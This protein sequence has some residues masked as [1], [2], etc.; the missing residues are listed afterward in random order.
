[1]DRGMTIPVDA[2]P[3]EATAGRVMIVDDE[4]S[5]RELLRDLL[6]LWGH[7]VV[8]AGSGE[9]AIR[10]AAEGPPDAILLDVMMP[11]M[12]G[13][14]VCRRLKEDPRTAAVPVLMVTALSSRDER[15]QGIEAGASDFLSK[16]IDRQD[17]HLR[18]RN[19]V[20]LKQLHDRVCAELDRVRKLEV[21]RD[22][23]VHWIVHDMRSPLQGVMLGVQMLSMQLGPVLTERQKS[24]VDHTVGIL[25]HVGEMA[26]T[27]LDVS[28]MEGGQ[29]PLHLGTCEMKGIV[30]RSLDDLRPLLA[31]LRI[32]VDAPAGPVELQ[33]DANLVERILGNL[34]G[35]AA[36]F[37]P[38]GG[39]LRVAILGSS[40]FV[41]IE[42][43]DTGPGIPAR[44]Q[45]LIFEKF[46][47]AE[48]RREHCRYSTGLGLAFCRLAVE[49]HGGRI[50]VESE[51]G[52]GSTFWFEL[53]VDAAT[54][55]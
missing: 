10:M 26:S 33:A 54:A 53:P 29:F 17:V 48:A 45:D 13:F 11:G 21:L 24:S 36:K 31:H 14:E 9:E 51:V 18:V 49:A 16:P 3:V 19:A 44:H 39:E 8:E 6:E 20:R 4:A 38:A 2:P 52:R 40:R 41:R 50:G 27:V 1:M 15:L 43:T 32:E 37:T 5:T 30:Q 55:A 28:R 25:R 7:L 46:G 22:N 12:D 35:N 47:Q 23:L 34:I 42:V